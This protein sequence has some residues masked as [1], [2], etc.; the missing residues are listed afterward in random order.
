MTDTSLIE[1]VSKLEGLPAWEP[2]IGPCGFMLQF[3]S[4]RIVLNRIDEGDF[5]L[6]AQCD[7]KVSG[8]GKLYYPRCWPV[9]EDQE[10][11]ESFL[12]TPAVIKAAV[13]ERDNSLRL[14]LHE[15]VL[16]SVFP[17]ENEDDGCWL[18]YDHTGTYTQIYIVTQ[19][20]IVIKTD[21][22]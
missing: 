1:T 9:E 19:R 22:G 6:W 5:T 11:L 20:E 4:K 21:M 12:I 2:L 3:G 14:L 8:H 18:L 10:M 7:I 16:L 13:D 17:A 15:N